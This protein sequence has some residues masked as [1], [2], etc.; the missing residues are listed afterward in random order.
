VVAGVI[1]SSRLCYDLWGDSVN[2]AQRL[3]ASSEQNVIHV[4]E[5]VYHRL[6]AA[7][8]LEDRGVLDLKDIGPT[9]TFI[10]RGSRDHARFL[11]RDAGAQ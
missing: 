8:D 11:A 1:G 6:R 10:L 5:P 9:R 3:E 2:L 7:F 4:S